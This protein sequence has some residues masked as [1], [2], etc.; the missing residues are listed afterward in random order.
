M[1]ASDAAFRDN[2]LSRRSIE[3]YWFT[4]FGGAINW[5]STKQT[6]VIKLSTEAELTALSYAGTE[7]I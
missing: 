3:G 7:L 4:L 1:G 6:L 5:R 2:L